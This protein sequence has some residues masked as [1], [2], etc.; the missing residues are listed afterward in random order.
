MITDSRTIAPMIR[1]FRRA[2]LAKAFMLPTVCYLRQ[3]LATAGG[4]FDRGQASWDSRTC[5]AARDGVGCLILVRLNV[6]FEVQH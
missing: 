1:R 5:A 6:L 4:G 2:S 3:W